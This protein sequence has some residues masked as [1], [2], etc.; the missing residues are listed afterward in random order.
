MSKKGFFIVFEGIEGSGKSYQAKILY[1]KLKKLNKKVILTREPGGTKSAEIIRKII[2]KDYFEKN[3]KIKF[4]KYTDTL[5]YLAS[6]N[7]HV[8]NKIKPALKQGNIVICDRFIDS[9]Y[10]YQVEGK[11]VQNDF[12]K[13][14]HNQ[15]IGNLR[16]NLTI[17]LKV[18]QNSFVRRLQK[19]KTRN[20]YDNF[21]VKFYLKAQRSFIKL[22]RNK[23]NYVIFDS[24]KN[25]T[26]L[27]N[28]IFR[29]IVNRI[30]LKI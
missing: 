18:Q 14:I 20:R 28:L 9:T 17:V 4:D 11:K 16:P 5:L 22:S 13:K 6:R 8:K 23:K 24:S 12:I 27:Q 7:E 19:R 15:I 25:T 2:L 21:P 1:N 3:K 10:A 30:N 29:L 26:E